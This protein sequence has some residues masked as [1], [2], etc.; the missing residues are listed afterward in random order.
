M[1]LSDHGRKAVCQREIRCWIFKE[2]RF[3]TW[4]K[5]M[6]ETEGLGC[7]VSLHRNMPSL[8]AACAP[9]PPALR[10]SVAATYRVCG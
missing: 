9:R 5:L 6:E 10:S 1:M 3:K 4:I 7:R 2:R 8:S